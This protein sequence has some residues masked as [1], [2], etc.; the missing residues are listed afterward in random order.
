VDINIRYSFPADDKLTAVSG[1]RDE[2]ISSIASKET[3]HFFG[4]VARLLNRIEEFGGSA[5]ELSSEFAVN[6][7]EEGGAVSGVWVTSVSQIGAVE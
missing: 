1:V 4:D 5:G 3:D 6:A 2:S 7:N